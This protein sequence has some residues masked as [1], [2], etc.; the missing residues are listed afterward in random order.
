MYPSLVSI[1]YIPYVDPMGYVGIPVSYPIA[2][3]TM[4]TARPH[5]VD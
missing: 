4:V 1:Y 5:L 2:I 3:P